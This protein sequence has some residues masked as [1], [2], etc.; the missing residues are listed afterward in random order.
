M[1]D[2]ALHNLTWTKPGLD[3][4][5]ELKIRRLFIRSIVKPY[6]IRLKKCNVP[7]IN[8]SAQ[9]LLVGHFGKRIRN[10]LKVFKCGV[11]E[12]WISVGQIMRGGKLRS[13]T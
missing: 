1:L 11:G 4:D 3:I 13:I 9:K 12:G 5:S 6:I 2:S 8:Y 7:Q 10:N